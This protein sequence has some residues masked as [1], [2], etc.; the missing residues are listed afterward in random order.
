[1]IIVVDLRKDS[2]LFDIIN[3]AKPKI[4]RKA[5]IIG[6]MKNLVGINGSKDWLPH[7]KRGSKFDGGDEYLSHNLFKEINV[8][9]QE[10]IDLKDV[11]CKVWYFLGSNHIILSRLLK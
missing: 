6:D 9:L 4:H 10:R 8:L 11:I 1:M 7:H 3:L 5:G 2:L